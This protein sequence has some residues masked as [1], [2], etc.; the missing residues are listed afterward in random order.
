MPAVSEHV[1]GAAAAAAIGTAIAAAEWQKEESVAEVA[2]L[3]DVSLTLH[4]HTSHGTVAVLAQV[5][6]PL[7]SLGMAFATEASDHKGLVHCLEHLCFMGSSQ[8][9]KGYLDLL[10][11]RCGCE[12]VN[13]YTDAD[14]TCFE[15][16]TAGETGLL[17]VL[18]VFV[19]HVLCP[20]LTEEA[21]VTEVHHI[22]GKGERQGVV[23]SEM[24]GRMTD[25]EELLDLEVRRATFGEDSPYSYEHGGMPDE[26]MK[27]TRENIKSYHKEVYTTDNLY[28]VVS[29]TFDESKVLSVL[30]RALDSAVGHG[31][32]QRCGRRPFV[33]ALPPLP[34]ACP[35]RRMV[36]FPTDDI[37]VGSVAY[38]RRLAGVPCTDVSTI[39]ALEVL[40]RYLTD[41]ASSPLEQAFV[42]C[43]P[44][45][46]SGVTCDIELRA[47]P[48]F[49]IHLSGVPFHA[50]D[51]ERAAAKK[52]GGG[53]GEEDDDEDDG[54]ADEEGEDDEDES[55][56]GQESGQEEGE[57]DG[58]D[59]DDET[60]WFSGDALMKRLV[61]ELRQVHSALQ[62]GD[63]K[64]LADIRRSVKK[65]DVDRRVE[66]EDGPNQFVSDQLLQY[67]IFR[68][69]PTA[70]ADLQG[71]VLK[72]MITSVE[73]LESYGSKPAAWWA[74]LL[75]EHFL[76]PLATTC[77]GEE[78]GVA[79]VRACPS[80]VAC[81]SNERKQE[82]EAK[83]NAKKL[84]K[85][86][87]KA[88]QEVVDAA[89]E[90]NRVSLDGKQRSIFP[91]PVTPDCVPD[92]R[93]QMELIPAPEAGIE[94]L[95]V[96]VASSFVE[97]HVSWLLDTA[98]LPNRDGAE[99]RPYLNLFTTLITETDVAGES[100]KSV[101]AR[102]D[103]ELVSYSAS[104]DCASELLHA[105]TYPCQFTLKLTAEPEKV[106][107]LVTWADRLAHEC[108]F[109]EEK[110]LA[111]CRRM[112][113]DLKE[114]MRAGETVLRE[115]MTA[116]TH[117]PLSPPMQLGALS[118][119][120][121]LQ[122]C[123]AQKSE[124]CEVLQKLRD[125]ITAPGTA[126]AAVISGS[127]A[128]QRSDIRSRLQDLWRKR[129]AQARPSLFQAI[130]W[131]AVEKRSLAPLL[132][133][134]HLAVGCAGSD[135][136]TVHLRAELPLPPV[137]LDGKRSWSLRLLCET[138]SMM[139]GPLSQAIRGKG[140]AYGASVDFGST[141]NVVTLDLWECTN[142]R[143]AV[144]A[145]L[146]VVRTAI[147]DEDV[148]SQFQVDNARGSLV[149]S[150]KQ[151]RGTPTSVTNAAVGAAARG[152]R[153][154]EEVL[155]WE[156][157]LGQ[158]TKEDIIDA[159]TK[160][161]SLLCNTANVT[162][163]VVCDPGDCKKMAK[164]L[165]AGLGL[166]VSKIFVKENIS[167]S[168]EIVD[169]RIQAALKELPA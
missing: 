103:D 116:A 9:N 71:G 78:G 87:L 120:G 95:E 133:L 77:L 147:E 20:S 155:A 23:F 100:Y 45:I 122:K 98:R 19:D 152:W 143:K 70:E 34:S 3:Q 117:S 135:T 25:E 102:L 169:G 127:T 125:V 49:I 79:E 18:P 81:L 24:L 13:A 31:A 84:G 46:A 15:L 97:L 130:R 136:A 94:T 8:Y 75:E 80:A 141:Q 44:P 137:A 112:L 126:S 63:E 142:V 138:L 29:G 7:C 1:E 47:D 88:L 132:P 129:H 39:G 92:Y 21:F 55:E 11:K 145:A 85:K 89:E 12:G 123:I 104:T 140:L 153:T 57:T 101:V 82:R 53:Q 52:L 38:S 40:G 35:R 51:A 148:L 61:D 110:V 10:A 131:I 90:A 72:T 43:D 50:S 96:E 48:H 76:K 144:E 93:W 149:F 83:A 107:K 134:R 158:T 66:F 16:T 106:D 59:E 58:A 64:V 105:S 164:N 154:K 109:S 167:D 6:G 168:Y 5:G 67:L 17:S 157:M 74:E 37:S 159:H 42:Q 22:N 128:E 111:T 30:G 118:Q 32:R 68:H 119:R 26:I 165:A 56:E 86:K 150:M 114:G 65:S 54:E 62:S 160:Y 69:Y 113:S 73:A 108:E 151:A 4:R 28:I 36:T 146:C 166:D 14:H 33:A 161:L 91:A 162:A 121:F 124:T 2:G 27:L 115:V 139:E 163:C 41:L 99:M 60:D 156:S